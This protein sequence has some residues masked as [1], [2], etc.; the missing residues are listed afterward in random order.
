MGR[1]VDADK[2]MRHLRAE[3]NIEA[4]I[5]DKY[6]KEDVPIG[7]VKD[8]GRIGRLEGLQWCRNNLELDYY[9]VEAIPKA[10]YEAKLKADLE[11]VLNK[12][13]AEIEALEEGITSY[14][15]GR[16]RIFKDEVF[17]IIDKYCAESEE[18]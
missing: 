13:R 1:L 12:I 18:I 10:D 2:Y 14:H 16:P 5:I 11:S 8:C 4:D 17:A 15:N 3:I 7:T 6:L 9:T